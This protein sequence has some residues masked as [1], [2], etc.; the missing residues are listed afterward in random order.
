MEK[1]SPINVK[2]E[3]NKKSLISKL[4]TEVESWK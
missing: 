3:S 4:G 2:A 1:L